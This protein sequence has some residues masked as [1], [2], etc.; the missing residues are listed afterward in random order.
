M[1]KYMNELSG[2]GV[3]GCT[4]EKGNYHKRL[5]QTQW[6]KTYCQIVDLK[7]YENKEYQECQSKIDELQSNDMGSAILNTL[8]SLVGKNS[9]GL[10]GILMV[11]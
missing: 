11:R 7:K 4:G 5:T 10:L 6:V 1:N 9:A 2:S 3:Q 8:E